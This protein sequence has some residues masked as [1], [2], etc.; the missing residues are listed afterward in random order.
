M[1]FGHPR[2]R[3]SNTRDTPPYSVASLLG[4]PHFGDITGNGARDG[5]LDEEAPAEG[6]V[7]WRGGHQ[8][9]LDQSGIEWPPRPPRRGGRGVGGEE[10]VAAEGVVALLVGEEEDVG[11]GGHEGVSWVRWPSTSR[12]LPEFHIERPV[13]FD[14]DAPIGQRERIKGSN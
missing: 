8:E 11:L 5:G 4:P 2:T 3:S 9:G 14:A 7:F 10:A 6:R 1:S 12:D 13:R